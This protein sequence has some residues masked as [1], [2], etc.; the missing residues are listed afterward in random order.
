MLLDESEVKNMNAEDRKTIL[1]LME[2][3]SILPD[4]GREYLLGFAEGVIAAA[5]G[6]HHS[7]PAPAR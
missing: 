6:E 2:A 3:V 1:A 7:E 4:S 5:S